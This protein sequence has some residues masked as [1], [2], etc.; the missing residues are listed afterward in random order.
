MLVVIPDIGLLIN[1]DRILADIKEIHEIFVDLNDNIAK[2]LD[3][4]SKK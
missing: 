4:Q 3:R 1:F 2:D